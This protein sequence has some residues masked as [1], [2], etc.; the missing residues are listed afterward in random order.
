MFMKLENTS[1][2]MLFTELTNMKYLRFYS[3]KRSAGYSMDH[4]VCNINILRKWGSENPGI[5]RKRPKKGPNYPIIHH[6]MY[7]NEFLWN[8][9]GYFASVK[10]WGFSGH[11]SLKNCEKS[12][13]LNSKADFSKH[14]KW[15]ISQEWMDR[16]G[17]NST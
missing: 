7:F 16:I 17:C 11:I 14:T 4:R 6:I 1:F 9:E 2:S 12:C 15:I 5:G 8:F 10:F 13:F 3:N